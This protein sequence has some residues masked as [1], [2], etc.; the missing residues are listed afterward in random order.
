ME[1]SGDRTRRR[2]WHP[3][4]RIAFTTYLDSST[5]II[6]LLGAG[7]STASG[8]TTFRGPGSLWRQ[9]DPTSL[10][11]P[12]AFKR[13]PT[14]V[15]LFYEHRRQLALRAAPNAGHVA[16]AELARA[17]PELLTVTQ[18]IDGEYGP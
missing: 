13:D 12:W 2:E 11:S 4:D 5:Y 9:H 7:L 1:T 16:L 17:K 6:A 15:W 8:L 14:L 18:N 10:A 3:S